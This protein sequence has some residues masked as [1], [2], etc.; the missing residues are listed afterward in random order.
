MMALIRNLGK[1]TEM[2]LFKNEDDQPANELL[3]KVCNSLTNEEYL[4]NARIH[5]L[6]ILRALK[7]YREGWKLK[8]SYMEDKIRDWTPNQRILDA[9]DDAFY[10]TLKVCQHNSF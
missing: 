3:E 6:F 10:K 7:V 9:L 2:E 4:C 1:L 5:P 8:G